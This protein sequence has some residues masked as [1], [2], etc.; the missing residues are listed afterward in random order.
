M[1]PRVITKRNKQTRNI[2]FSGSLG[3]PFSG[4]EATEEPLLGTLEFRF[5]CPCVPQRSV[6]MSLFL[7][8]SLITPPTPAFQPRAGGGQQTQSSLCMGWYVSPHPSTLRTQCP[9]CS[10]CPAP[11]PST[12]QVH[13]PHC[14]WLLA[15][16]SPLILGLQGIL[17]GFQEP[18]L[19]SLSPTLPTPQTLRA[20]APGPAMAPGAPS[21]SPS[22]ILAA[23]LFSSLGKWSRPSLGAL[24]LRMP[25]NNLVTAFAAVPTATKERAG[26]GR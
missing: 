24:G 6:F 13:M 8:L 11:L 15:Q 4:K 9:F 22:P 3:E 12:S 5:P 26:A 14:N 21:S 2:P 18:P 7:S 25:L 17:S 19:S 23:L 20:L 10:L 1:Q 16:D